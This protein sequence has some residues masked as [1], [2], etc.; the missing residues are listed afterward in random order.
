MTYRGIRG[1]LLLLIHNKHAFPD[2]LSKIPTPADISPFL[3]ITRI[4]N[5]PL[6]PWLLIN[7]Y[8]PSHE[9]DLPLIPTIQANITRQINTH[10]NHTYILCGDF[11][12]D[13]ALIGRQN[14]QQTTPPQPED[15]LWHSFITS[16]EL[17][18]IPT[19][20]TFSRQGGHNYTQ[21]SII[22]GFYTNIPHNQQFTSTTIQQYT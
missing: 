4:A 14:D 22:D 21:N 17:S 18:Y 2:N 13:V 11:N 20:T 9:D 8:M 3:Q 16:L 7:L 10:P 6:Q 19:N 1:G 5:Q 15:Y 12:R